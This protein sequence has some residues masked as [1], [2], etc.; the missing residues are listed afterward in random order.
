MLYTQKDIVGKILRNLLL[1]HPF[2]GMYTSHIIEFEGKVE[3]VYR[4]CHHNTENTKIRNWEAHRRAEEKGRKKE[5]IA[6]ASYYHA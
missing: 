5:F 4:H 6:R 1:P 2:I 3:I